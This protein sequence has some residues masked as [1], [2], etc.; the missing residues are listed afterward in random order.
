MWIWN[1][2]KFL[3]NMN[4]VISK[5]RSNNPPKT[6]NSYLGWIFRIFP[7]NVR[8]FTL[9]MM[10]CW[11]S[12]SI[13]KSQKSL[14][15]EFWDISDSQRFSEFSL[16][17]ILEIF[18]LKSQIEAQKSKMKKSRNLPFSSNFGWV[19]I[20]ESSSC[21]WSIIWRLETAM[22]ILAILLLI[23][24]ALLAMIL[25]WWLAWKKL[26]DLALDE[27][28]DDGDWIVAD[29]QVA[30]GVELH[31]DHNQILKRKFSK[32]SSRKWP[33]FHLKFHF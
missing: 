24:V 23:L 30:Y 10:F 31:V 14:E 15:G 29:I 33:N 4:F 26:L 19:M 9:N 12:S 27:N 5:S 7:W 6:R 32:F 1:I 13:W 17:M 20:N 28:N 3:L 21:T 25:E 8:K 2:R 11:I 22:I 18:I 16:I